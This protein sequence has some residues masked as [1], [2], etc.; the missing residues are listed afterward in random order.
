MAG[1]H[2]GYKLKSKANWVFKI[3]L[4]NSHEQFFNGM[5]FV[6]LYIFSRLKAMQSL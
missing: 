5:K 1:P 2:D 3:Y 6:V 4:P